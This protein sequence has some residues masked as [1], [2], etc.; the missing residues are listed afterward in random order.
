MSDITCGK[1]SRGAVFLDRDGTIIEDRGYLSEPEDVVWYE[2]AFSALIRLSECF[3]LFIV[4]NQNGVGKGMISM[5]AV[6]RVN[7]YIASCL[8]RHGVPLAATYVCPHERGSGCRCMKPSPYFLEKAE[9]DFRIDLGR[10]F[11]I[12]DHPQD[13]KLAENA[14]A[15]GIYVLSGHGEKHRDEIPGDAIVADG[16]GEAAEVILERARRSGLSR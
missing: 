11:V 5:E 7:A 8:R 9:G 10:S 12:G 3:R 2:E 16:I 1:A 15:T 4:T 13:A 14:G 6:D